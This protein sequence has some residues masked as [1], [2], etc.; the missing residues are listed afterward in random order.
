M[1]IYCFIIYLERKLKGEHIISHYQV[2]WSL[3][4]VP[5]HYQIKYPSQI[6]SF[7]P[8]GLIYFVLYFFYG[9]LSANDSSLFGAIFLFNCSRWEL[10]KMLDN[11][12]YFFKGII[13]NSELFQKML[14]SNYRYSSINSCCLV[15]CFLLILFP[16]DF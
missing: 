3:N 5:F 14:Q 2:F 15:L 11:F 13:I 7:P 12:S 1:F 4:M 16:N 6:F 8:K 10:Q 9:M